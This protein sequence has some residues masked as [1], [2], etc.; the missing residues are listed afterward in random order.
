[1][2]SEVAGK[3]E[4]KIIIEC[5]VDRVRRRSYEECVAVRD[6]FGRGVGG[7][8]T[9]RSRP[10]FNDEGLTKLLRQGLSNQPSD[11]IRRT[12]RSISNQ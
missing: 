5:C 1:M 4:F 9:A 6:R 11:G 10:I 12:S 7:D 3:I 2:Q 8:V